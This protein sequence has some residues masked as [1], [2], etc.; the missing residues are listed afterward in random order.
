[1]YPFLILEKTS[2][3]TIEYC[4]ILD[5]NN[6]IFLGTDIKQIYK[7]IY[8]I[9][10]NK[11]DIDYINNIFKNS[12][13]YNLLKTIYALSDKKKKKIEILYNKNKITITTN[14]VFLFESIIN[15]ETFLILKLYNISK[16]SDLKKIF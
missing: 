10:S 15:F 3:T 16:I 7:E 6:K 9:I 13:E 11:I 4:L 12:I 2:R 5:E 8:E 1:M 14:G